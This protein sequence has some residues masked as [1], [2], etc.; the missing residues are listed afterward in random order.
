MSAR[1]TTDPVCALTLSSSANREGAL[2]SH[3][4]F[5]LVPTRVS[6]M[7]TRECASR[8]DTSYRLQAPTHVVVIDAGCPKGG[9]VILCHL[10]AACLG[11]QGSG[12]GLVCFSAFHRSG[13]DG[14]TF[15]NSDRSK[16]WI[17]FLD[18]DALDI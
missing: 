13:R 7:A 5:F 3:D 4:P 18:Y 16:Y 1:Q 11:A 2:Y 12:S 6:R 14:Y 17:L 10:V 15:P 8:S 9:I